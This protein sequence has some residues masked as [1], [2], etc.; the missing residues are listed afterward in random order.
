MA[1]FGGCKIVVK[2][3]RR[4]W[5]VGILKEETSGINDRNV[6]IKKPSGALNGDFHQRTQQLR[7]ILHDPQRHATA[8]VL[9]LVDEAQKREFH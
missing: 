7:R 4:W 9:Q 2:F 8:R 3:L 1:K 5:A 6:T